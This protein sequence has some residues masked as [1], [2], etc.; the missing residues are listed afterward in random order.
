V[1]FNSGADA[2][3]RLPPGSWYVAWDMSTDGEAGHTSIKTDLRNEITVEGT[4][5]TILYQ[6]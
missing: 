1:I 6:K 3:V 2:L 4:A 5:V